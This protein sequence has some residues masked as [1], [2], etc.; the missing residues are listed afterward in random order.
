MTGRRTLLL[1]ALSLPL[2]SLLTAAPTTAA[3]AAAPAAAQSFYVDCGAA[4]AGDGTQAAPWNALAPVNSHT[5]QPGDSILLKR[6]STCT[7]QTLFPKGSGAVGAPVVVD[8][9][10]TGA[11]PALAGA[12][13]VTDVVRL[14][15]Q[16]YWEIRNLDVSNKGAAAATRRGVHVT[17]T[18]S[19]TG[20]YYRLTGL[21]VH[22]V[23]GNQTK[24]DD[25]A[26]AGIFFEVLGNT[27]PTKFDDVALTGNTVRA[28]DRY[29]IHFWTRWMQR[30]ELANANCGT[31]CGAWTPQTRVVIRGNTVSDIGGDAIVPHHTEGAL[32]EYNKVDGFREREPAHCAAGLWGWNTEDAL[33]QFNEVSGGRSTCDG[34]G[35]DLDEGNIRTIYQ[36][37]Y[38]HDNEGGFILLCNGGGSTT[39]D[40]VVRYNI[41]QNDGGQLFD[42]V[43]AKAT[44]T[45]IYNNTFYLSKPVEII[46]NSNGSTAANATF[47]NNIFHVATADAS[48]VNAAGLGYD[49]NVFYG[50]H[51]AGEPADAHK[52][53]TDPKLT[54]PGTATSRTDADGYRLQAGSSALANGAVVANAG[55]RDY[56][57]GPVTAGCVPDR[58]AQQSSTACVQPTG[59]AAGIN[60][61]SAGTQAIDVPAHSTAQGTQLVGWLW[62]GGDNQKWNVTADTDGTYTLKNVTSGLC[63]EVYKNSKAAGAA[64]DQWACSGD[65]NQRWTATPAAG[66]Y[67]LTSRSSGLLLTAASTTNGALLTQQ[68]PSTTA[69][70]TWSFT[71]VS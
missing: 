21:D 54:A 29:G 40:N 68:A 55:V 58:G 66:G 62:N 60:R 50:T 14:A 43:C 34:Q 24:K 57:G 65:A 37:N 51:P 15:D 25:D 38:S 49:A 56:F 31:T 9:Y 23:N 71:K 42:M 39:A 5:F 63:A 30:P 70:Q 16:Q 8:A 48:Y 2:A 36:Y 45:Q 53:T 12:G 59:P 32:I 64:I 17:R 26:S 46:S 4:A 52:V 61:I 67:R 44:N 33:Y 20:T 35:L 13:Q 3:Q 19:G 41:S 47:T 6:G 27:T 22:D 11:K 10:G 7:G 1:S 18:D 28:V 69:V